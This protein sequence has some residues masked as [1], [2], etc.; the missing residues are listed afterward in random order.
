MKVKK[1]EKKIPS[2]LNK[3]TVVNMLREYNLHIPNLNLNM[4]Q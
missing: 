1:L 3:K 2:F 4:I